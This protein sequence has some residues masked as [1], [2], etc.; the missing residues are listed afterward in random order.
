MD[1]KYLRGAGATIDSADI[2]KQREAERLWE[3]YALRKDVDALKRDEAKVKAEIEMQRER[4]VA[5]RLT[6]AK[7]AIN[8][9]V[10]EHGAPDMTMAEAEVVACAM[11]D[12]LTE[13]WS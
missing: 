6:A 2:D 11:L 5:H 3:D 13:L 12:V 7:Q 8:L 4:A 1:E 9:V 10:W